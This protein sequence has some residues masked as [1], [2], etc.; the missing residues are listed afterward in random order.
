MTA[1]G[2]HYVLPAAVSV[3][4]D[5]V[6]VVGVALDVV[7]VVVIVGSVSVFAPVFVIFVDAVVNLVFVLEKK[8]ISKT[9]QRVVDLGDSRPT[10][11]C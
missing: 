7:V 10:A 4:P 1:V 3:A 8:R 6:A 9:L 11:Y 5:V 2:H